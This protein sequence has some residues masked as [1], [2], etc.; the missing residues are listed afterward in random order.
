MVNCGGGLQKIRNQILE[1]SSLFTKYFPH[2]KKHCVPPPFTPQTS[3]TL[4]KQYISR[5]IYIFYIYYIA[6]IL[7]IIFCDILMFD[8]TFLS[9]QVKRIVII[10]NKHGIQ[11]LPHELPNVLRLRTL[12][13]QE[14]LRR[15]QNFIELQ[16]GAQSCF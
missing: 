10:S 9:R 12:G 15:S 5:G 8:K 6:T 3:D 16:P 4:I 1:S 14:I 11:V 2:Q 7:V 13:N